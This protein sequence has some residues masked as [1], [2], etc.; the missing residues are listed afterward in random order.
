[1]KHDAAGLMRN[2]RTVGDMFTALD[3]PTIGKGAKLPGSHTFADGCQWA[4]T[5]DECPWVE[6]C[7]LGIR[8]YDYD[9]DEA[10]E[11]RE[12]AELAIK[13]S[14]QSIRKRPISGVGQRRLQ[15][16][17]AKRSGMS[18][19]EVA[20]KFGVHIRTV[21]RSVEWVEGLHDKPWGRHR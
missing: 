8:R 3:A 6:D 14:P 19:K 21:R 18:E 20:V 7:V 11:I 16:V 15:I 5:C 10:K 9:S 1:M 2:A 13:R 17:G 4:R 12:M